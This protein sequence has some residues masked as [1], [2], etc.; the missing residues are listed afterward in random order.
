[1]GNGFTLYPTNKKQLNLLNNQVDIKQGDRYQLF[2]QGA[3]EVNIFNE[4]AQFSS[5]QN[6]ESKS[7]KQ[8]VKIVQNR[9]KIEN[10]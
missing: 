2:S 7:S 5:E 10:T 6:M 4:E 8:N 3:A 9:S 1:M